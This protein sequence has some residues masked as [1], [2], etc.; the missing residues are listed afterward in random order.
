MRGYV[1][2]QRKLLCMIYTLWKKN[3]VFDPEYHLEKKEEKIDEI[4]Q[5]DVEAPLFA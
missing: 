4:R 2:V 5:I 1:A 3:E